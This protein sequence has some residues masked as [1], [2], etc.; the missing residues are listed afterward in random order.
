LIG[1]Y[2]DTEGIGI[3][4]GMRMISIQATRAISVESPPHGIYHLRDGHTPSLPNYARIQKVSSCYYRI[5]RWYFQ[6]NRRDGRLLCVY[7]ILEML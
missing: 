5:R 7:A 2:F 4:L 3:N 6:W 1:S